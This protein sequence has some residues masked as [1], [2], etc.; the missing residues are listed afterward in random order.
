M[1]AKCISI[2]MILLLGGS[3]LAGEGETQLSKGISVVEFIP[4]LPQ[5][6]SGKVLKGSLLL[7]A[8]LTTIVGAIWKNQE[9]ND[10]YDQYLLST[11]VEEVIE[12][13]AK[14]EKSYRNRNYF[15]IGMVSVWVLHL[16]DLKFFK[17]KKGGVKGEVKNNSLYFG[18]YYSF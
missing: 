7:G 6:I 15:I 8:C 9:G 12:L 14:A 4:G 1:S 18:F 2:V 10:Y 16:L 3:W 5:L 17:N 11:D 13:R